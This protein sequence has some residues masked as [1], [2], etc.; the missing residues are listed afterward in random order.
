MKIEMTPM[1]VLDSTGKSSLSTLIFDWNS[2]LRG[3]RK[4]EP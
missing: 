1:F 2:S 3:K 4:E